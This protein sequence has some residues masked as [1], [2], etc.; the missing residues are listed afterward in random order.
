MGIVSDLGLVALSMTAPLSPPR[1]G[2]PLPAYSQ[3]EFGF[4]RFGSSNY[5]GVSL[6]VSRSDLSESDEPL[7]KKKFKKPERKRTKPIRPIPI[8]PIPSARV[9]FNRSTLTQ[10]FLTRSSPGPPK[11]D[12]SKHPQDKRSRVVLKL[13]RKILL[14]R[15]LCNYCDHIAEYARSSSLL[16]TKLH[17]YCYKHRPRSFK[18][19]L[20]D[21]CSE[22]YCWSFAKYGYPGVRRAHCPSHYLQGMVKLA[23]IR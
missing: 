21:Y 4:T 1:M 3:D 14:T 15:D 18:M 7:I 13:N 5:L 8:R 22:P 16:Q 11:N 19:K 12:R 9:T 23:L 17:F 10:S 20:V 2:S 6:S